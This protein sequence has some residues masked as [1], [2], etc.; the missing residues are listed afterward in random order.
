[1]Y[2]ES[3]EQ[4]NKIISGRHPFVFPTDAPSSVSAGLEG[5]NIPGLNIIISYSVIC[6][7]PRGAAEG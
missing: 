6:S 2:L 5:K 7:P 1:M 4:L 3:Y